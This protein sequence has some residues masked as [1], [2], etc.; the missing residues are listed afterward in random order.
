MKAIPLLAA[1][2]ALSLFACTGNLP[3]PVPS[4]S[5]AAVTLA[6]SG[7]PAA[8]LETFTVDLDDV[9]WTDTD[10]RT[11]RQRLDQPRL[12]L[13][14]LGATGAVVIS[15]DLPSATY[16]KLQLRLDFADAT[17]HIAGDATAAAIVDAEGNLLRD[18][19]TV[20]LTFA[21]PLVI[22]G[23]M[24]TLGS[25]GLQPDHALAIDRTRRQVTFTP[26]FRFDVGGTTA[27]VALHATLIAVDEARGRIIVE[28][29]DSARTRPA[30]FT[31]LVDNATEY[32]LDG[33][34]A[35][36]ATGLAAL[37]AAT[38]RDLRLEIGGTT[39]STSRTI[40]AASIRAGRGA[41]SSAS[42]ADDW[43]V[44][45]VV[46][47][48]RGPGDDASLTV[49]GRSFDAATGTQ[50]FGTAH[51]V[52]VAFAA[53]RV[54]AGIGTAALTTD[55]INVGQR[56]AV[57]GSLAGTRMDAA[58]FGLIHLQATEILGVANR[59]AADGRVIVA[60][61]RIG[62]LLPG[63]FAFRVGGTIEAEPAAFSIELPATAPAIAAGQ[64]VHAAGRRGS[65]GVVGDADLVATRIENRSTA[66]T[67][68]RLACQWPAPRADGIA[69]A[70]ASLMLDISAATTRVVRIGPTE[71]VL[72]ATPAPTLRAAA[73][74]GRGS[75][76]SREYTI[77]DDNGVS[78]TGDFSAFLAEIQSR[79]TANARVV[80][81][82]GAGSFDAASQTLTATS[83]TVE[84]R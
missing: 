29:S 19:V 31:V 81:L 74:S 65:V 18:T 51:A 72:N 6:V 16:T 21:E 2:A 67:G 84:L 54:V 42:G 75:T 58:S 36:G 24:H 27:S 71:T 48:D 4:S 70:A 66:G 3:N 39:T 82:A 14:D 5:T 69:V 45:H 83:L 9:V 38:A 50:R 77:V 47:R 46:A 22:E 41:I 55:A 37:A 73:A 32:Q 11:I 17:A 76:S 79:L 20:G 53:T 60:V 15:A 49:L 68:A 63:A 44:G 33:T 13:A 23:G 35:T 56:V 10:G 59:A 25:L 7:T 40:A 80:R 1:A 43:V 26:A 61:D 12:D 30:R 57:F 62:G 64:A 52:D 34:P 28:P 78:T 8:E